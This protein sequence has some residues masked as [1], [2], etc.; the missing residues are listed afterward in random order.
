MAQHEATTAARTN[1]ATRT[2]AGTGAGTGPG[3]AHSRLRLLGT[4]QLE[5]ADGTVTVPANAQRLLAFLGLHKRAPRTVVAGALW[6]DVTE[7]HA[8]GSLRTALWRLRRGRQPIVGTHGDTLCLADGVI[9]DV[10][11]FNRAALGLANSDHAPGD[12]L[13]LPVVLDG[14]EL[15]CGWDEEWVLFERERLRQLRLHALESLS[16]LLT[17]HGRYALALEAALMCVTVE[18]L[19]ES[20]HRAVAAVHLAENNMVEVVRRYETFRMLINEELGLEP[21]A[22]F[23]GMLPRRGRGT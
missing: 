4:F 5:G 23:A 6:P 22:R 10:D 8:H 18:P 20:A 13:P 14:G 12:D 21:S 16:A 1:G 19:R 9:V 2:G 11:A 7:E 15:L 3:R 17:E